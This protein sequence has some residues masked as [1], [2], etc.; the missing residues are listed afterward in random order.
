MPSNLFRNATIQERQAVKS[1]GDQKTGEINWETCKTYFLLDKTTR[2]PFNMKISD[3]IKKVDK[4]IRMA[5]RQV[6]SQKDRL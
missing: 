1:N 4:K 5:K 3:I 6:M 2:L